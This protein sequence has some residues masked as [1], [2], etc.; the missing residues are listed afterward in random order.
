MACLHTNVI[1][2]NKGLYGM[3]KSRQRYYMVFY[4]NTSSVKYPMCTTQLLW[5][6]RY[7]MMI[8]PVYS[9]DFMEHHT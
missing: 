6:Q 1:L 9:T 7:F 4:M 8:K 5:D 2:M 3:K